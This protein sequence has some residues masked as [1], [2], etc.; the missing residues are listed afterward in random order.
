[1]ASRGVRGF[2]WRL[3]AFVAS[4]GVCGVSWRSWRLVAFVA[5]L[6]VSWCSWRLAAFKAF[7]GRM[8][9]FAVML[10]AMSVSILGHILSFGVKN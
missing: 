2:S 10:R 9:V 7:G 6:G 8:G 4:R 5:S 1:M 3:V